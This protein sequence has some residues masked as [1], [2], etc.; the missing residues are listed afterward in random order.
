MTKIIAI[1]Y[2]CV[3]YYWFLIKLNFLFLKTWQW[4]RGHLL[5]LWT[6]I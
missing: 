1:K 6:P 4:W 5:S 2:M 3:S